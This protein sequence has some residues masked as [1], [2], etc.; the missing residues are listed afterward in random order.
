MQST[1]INYSMIIKAQTTLFGERMG[2][3]GG[4][5]VGKLV[6]LMLFCC[7]RAVNGADIVFFSKLVKFS[8]QSILILF[9][10]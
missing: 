6:E 10:Q 9:T 4:K 8:K 7:N 3:G 2:R 5:K 1:L